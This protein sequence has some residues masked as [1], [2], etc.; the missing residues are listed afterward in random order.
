MNDTEIDQNFD[1][2]QNMFNDAK[3]VESEEKA[4]KEMERARTVMVMGQKPDHIFFATLV[5]KLKYKPDWTMPT[6]ATDGE[7]M[8]YNP[9]FMLSLSKEDVRFVHAHE[10][11]HCVYSHPPMMKRLAHL[12]PKKLNVAMDLVINWVLQEAKYVVPK[13]ACLPGRDQFKDIPPNLTTLETYRLLKDKHMKPMKGGGNDPGGFG[14]VIA[15][16]GEKRSE[17][18]VNKLEQDWKINIAQAANAAK[19][20]GT[21]S[22]NLDTLVG[23]ILKSKVNWKEITREFITK[24][25]KHEYTWNPPNKRFIGQDLYLPRMSGERLSRLIVANDT[26]GSMDMG[27]RSACAT[28]IQGIVEQL[29]CPLTI[30]HHDSQVCAVQEWTPED[31]KLVLGPKGGG[32]TSHVPVFEWIKENVEDELSG[33]ICLTDCMTCWPS[34]APEYPVLIASTYKGMGDKIPFGIYLEIDDEA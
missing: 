28:E 7:W 15:P 22:A 31:G 4:K 33:L 8:Y 17:A 6:A 12:D 1:A 21:M 24:M 25:T 10:V 14:G 16:H 9:D 13:M 26:S 27:P 3:R 23:E 11:M 29:G 34:E 19:Q 30:L 5:C 2:L 32:G 20:R 18:A